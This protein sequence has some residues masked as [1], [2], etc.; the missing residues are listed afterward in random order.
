MPK[1]PI[2]D[3][4]RLNY[5]HFLGSPTKLRFCY[6]LVV[7]ITLLGFMTSAYYYY[8]FDKETI[9]EIDFF[10]K[11]GDEWDCKS[12]GTYNGVYTFNNWSSLTFNLSQSPSIGFILSIDPFG[13]TIDKSPYGYHTETIPIS[14]SSSSAISLYNPQ[15]QFS[16]LSDTALSYEVT[17]G[18]APTTDQCIETMQEY[19]CSNIHDEESIIEDV[20][21][22]RFTLTFTIDTVD[23]VSHRMSDLGVQDINLYNDEFDGIFYVNSAAYSPFRNFSADSFE[24]NQ[25]LFPCFSFDGFRCH[26]TRS[27]LYA[28][29]ENGFK[30]ILVE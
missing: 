11:T 25:V 19:A 6:V 7:I 2:P 15:E 27:T 26:Q 23:G 8:I 28:E 16:A 5:P 29:C 10:V 13:W 20:H 30:F 21:V 22:Y 12:I 24:N 4:W 17:W 9:G 1:I 3:P 14:S 18:N